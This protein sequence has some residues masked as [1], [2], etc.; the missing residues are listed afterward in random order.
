MNRWRVIE[1]SVGRNIENRHIDIINY[2]IWDVANGKP[3]LAG[4]ISFFTKNPNDVG[5]A[6]M[7]AHCYFTTQCVYFPLFRLHFYNIWSDLDGCTYFN[8]PPFRFDV[9][10]LAL[11][12]LPF[13]STCKRRKVS[14]YLVSH[15]LSKQIERKTEAIVGYTSHRSLI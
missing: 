7:F 1:R 15:I 14:P 2:Y 4:E 8:L 9:E 6:G 12:H 11:G 5:V 10:D 13:H 3:T